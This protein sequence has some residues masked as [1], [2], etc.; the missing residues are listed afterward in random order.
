MQIPLSIRSL[1]AHTV[2]LLALLGSGSALSETT[3]P[4]EPDQV[5]QPEVSRLDVKIPKIKSSDF[6]IGAYAGILSV[7]DFGSNAVYGARLVY[8]VTEDYFVEGLYGRS[9]V[10]DQSFCDVGLCLFPQREEPLTYYALSLGYNLFPGEIFA[11][12]GHAMNSAVYLLAGVGNTSFADE[13]HF[14]FNVGLG[15]RVLPRDWLALHFT[16]RDYLFSTDYLGTSK[17]T[18]NVEL[19]GGLSVY[20]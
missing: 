14:T 8:H 10:S 4:N 19:T 3:I 16:I 18:S 7:E 20:F 6:E 13:S 11:G 15:L 5:I 1:S 2:L 17:L 9:T 12:K